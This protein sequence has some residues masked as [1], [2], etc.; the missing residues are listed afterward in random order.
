M[1]EK[2]KAI[3]STVGKWKK[4]KDKEPGSSVSGAHWLSPA[5]WGRKRISFC[6]Y[7]ELLIAAGRDSLSL[8]ANYCRKENFFCERVFKLLNYETNPLFFLT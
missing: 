8:I 5:A 3:S 2:V 7:I 1:Q 6:S 4:P